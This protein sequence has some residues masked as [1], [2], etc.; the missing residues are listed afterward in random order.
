MAGFTKC[1]GNYGLLWLNGKLFCL[2]W[3]SHLKFGLEI[4]NSSLQPLLSF[5]QFL[6]PQK[7]ANYTTCSIFV[8]YQQP[9]SFI[10]IGPFHQSSRPS[11]YMNNTKSLTID[12][13]LSL[14]TPRLEGWYGQVFH[15]TPTVAAASGHGWKLQ[16]RKSPRAH[17]RQ[18]T[19]AP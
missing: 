12:T 2:I 4:Q 16:Q 8:Q 17:I 7:A 15:P 3:A 11:I 6:A 10:N 18:G 19:L 1:V 5:A 13:L 9:P 14:A